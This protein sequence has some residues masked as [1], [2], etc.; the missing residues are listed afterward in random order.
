MLYLDDWLILCESVEEAIR[1]RQIVLDLMVELGLLIN[2]EKSNLT[3]TQTAVYLGMRIDTMHFRV[4]LSGK[5]VTKALSI[6]LKFT[7]ADQIT[8]KEFQVLIG[9]MCSMESLVSGA[10][11]RM[12]QF[13]FCLNEN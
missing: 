5:R 13:L 11:L 2:S 4:Y 8:A 9:H 7:Q 6:F 12:R 1:H 10:R 3:P